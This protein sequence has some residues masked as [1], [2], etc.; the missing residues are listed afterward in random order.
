MATETLKL[1]NY[2]RV[3]LAAALLHTATILETLN[4]AMGNKWRR[5]ENIPVSATELHNLK[6]DAAA[7]LAQ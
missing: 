7:P 1:L 5:I 6:N 4:N 2:Q 3:Q